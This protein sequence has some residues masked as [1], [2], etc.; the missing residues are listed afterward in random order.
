MGSLP[1]SRR[2]GQAAAAVRRVGIGVMLLSSSLAASASRLLFSICTQP[3]L[4]PLLALT[5]LPLTYFSRLKCATAPK[6]SF[7]EVQ[8]FF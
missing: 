7:T 3:I 8:K 6:R 2:R 1:A 5:G 4:L